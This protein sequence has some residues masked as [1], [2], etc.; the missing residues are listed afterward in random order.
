MGNYTVYMHVLPKEISGKENDKYY[1]G[2]T[3]QDPHK[4]WNGG[5][6]YHR[7]YI[8][9]AIS[10]YGWENFYHVIILNGL[11]L[12]EAC[13]KEKELIKKYKSN[14]KQYGY[15]IDNG[16]NGCGKMSEATKSIIRQ[17]LTGREFSAE[18][19]FKISQSLLRMYETHPHRKHTPEECAKIGAAQKGEKHWNYGKKRSDETKSKIALSTSKAKGMMV[20]NDMTGETYVSIREAERKT[21]VDRCTIKRCCDGLPVKKNHEGFRYVKRGENKT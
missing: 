4:R 1:I 15:N 16:G 11:S 17:K 19:R 13:E 12:D 8:G 9:Y 6:G 21:G 18:T 10:K 7:Q 14:Q 3:S 20:Y 2:I 5:R